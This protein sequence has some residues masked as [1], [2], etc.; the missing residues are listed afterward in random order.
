MRTP[1]LSTTVLFVL[2][3]TVLLM[4]QASFGES[5]ADECKTTPGSSGPLG[6]HWYYRI[7]RTDK[8]HCW[9]L[10]SEV[11]KV[12]SHELDAMPGVASQSS[13]PQNEAAAESSSATPTQSIPAQTTTMQIAPAELVGAETG[14]SEL[15]GSEHRSIDFATR[16]ADIPKSPDLDTHELVL[17]NNKYAGEH[18]TA[19]AAE[20]VPS[21]KPIIEVESAAR[22][23][24]SAGVANFG[25]VSLV[26][27][28]G[29]ASLLYFGL[30]F[31]RVFGIVRRP[32][33]ETSRRRTRSDFSEIRSDFSEIPGRG[34]TLRARQNESVWSPTL[35]DPA[36]DLRTSL[37]Q[38]MCDLKRA[39]TASNRLH[40]FVPIAHR[41]PKESADQK[42]SNSDRYNPSR[43]AA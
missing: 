2:P 40:S 36:R 25:L 29:I 42:L 6:T 39:G 5:T 9:Y 10:G 24:G 27:A 34:S 21:A 20:Q 37:H 35:T 15:P 19:N 31:G 38:L 4:A 33:R 22:P 26:G 14:S 11:M 30:Y 8:R 12:H 28:L 1:K 7:N 17:I 16:W 13:A 3:A 41:M 32:D 43:N 23:R 18:V